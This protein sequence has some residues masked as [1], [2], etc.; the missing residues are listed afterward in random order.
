MCLAQQAYKHDNEIGFDEPNDRVK[1]RLPGPLFGQTFLGPRATAREIL[2]TVR[3]LVEKGQ[4]DPMIGTTVAWDSPSVLYGWEG[5]S[6]PFLWLLRQDHFDVDIE[7]RGEIWGQSIFHFKAVHKSGPRLILDAL[8]QEK[9]YPTLTEARDNLGDSVLHQAVWA[10]CINVLE[11]EGERSHD[12]EVTESYT[13]VRRLLEIGSDVHAKN[14]YGYTPLDRIMK[15]IAFFLRGR[16]DT[17]DLRDVK[18]LWRSLVR[19]WFAALVNAGYSLREYAET[20]QSLRPNQI[21]KPFYQDKYS[22]RIIFLYGEDPN[23]VDIDLEEVEEEDNES[24]DI[25]DDE[26]DLEVEEP[27]PMPGSWQ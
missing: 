8:F 11:L 1:L 20:E 15:E 3:V 26:S 27:L 9:N 16:K 18:L 22:I 4:S 7:R 17:D 10:W 24:P 12:R 25:S 2:D 19:S 13:L 5:P 14:S 23:D 6:E 21:L